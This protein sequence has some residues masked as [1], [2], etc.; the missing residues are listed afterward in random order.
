MDSRKIGIASQDLEGGSG[1]Q[2][3][4]ASSM[5]TKPVFG[6]P[7]EGFS[8]LVIPQSNSERAGIPIQGDEEEEGT[9]VHVKTVP[10]AR[11]RRADVHPGFL[12]REL[13][14]LPATGQV[15]EPT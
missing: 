11:S 3:G 2:Q 4:I 8:P 13:Q 12:I 5:Q 6:A 10:T 15:L 7:T 14:G 9:G 1:K